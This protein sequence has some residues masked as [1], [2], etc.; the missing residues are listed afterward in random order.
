MPTWFDQHEDAKHRVRLMFPSYALFQADLESNDRWR[1][2]YTNAGVEMILG[3]W[4]ERPT[5]VRVG[6]LDGLL[7][8]CTLEGV[9]FGQSSAAAWPH[10]AGRHCPPQG[11]AIRGLGELHP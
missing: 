5:P 11:P 10:R 1:D 9:I 6:S 4:G 7:N 2:L 3:T 8:M